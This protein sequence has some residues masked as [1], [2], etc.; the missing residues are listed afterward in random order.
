MK[1][2]QFVSYYKRT[3]FAKKFYKI[4]QV[5]G[6]F[7]FTKNLAQ[8]VLENEIFETSYLY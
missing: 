8:P 5:P 6:P 1:I 2:D 4:P 3:N 7:V